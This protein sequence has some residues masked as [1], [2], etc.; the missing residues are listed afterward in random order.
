[1]C[2][3]YGE[4]VL[5]KNMLSNELNMSQSKKKIVHGLKTQWFSSKENVS[6]TAVSIEGPAWCS[7][8]WKDLI[9]INSQ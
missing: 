1:M 4:L 5:V 9:T 8:A 3:V 6:G 7:E 2:N